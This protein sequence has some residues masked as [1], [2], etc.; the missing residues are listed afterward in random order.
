MI[1]IITA[2]ILSDRSSTSAETKTYTTDMSLKQ[3]APDLNVTGKSLARELGLSQPAKG[4]GKKP[5]KELGVT[6]EKLDEV[7]EHLLS[8]KGKVLKYYLFAALF[9]GGLIFMLKLGRPEKASG[10]PEKEWYPRMPYYT[11]LILSVAFAGFYL[12]KSPNPM[13]GIVKVF[14]S[15]AGLYPDPWVKLAAFIFF[16]LLAIIGNKIICGWACPFGALQE[17]IYSIPFLIN[18]ENRIKNPLFSNKHNSHRS[19]SADDYNSLRPV[20]S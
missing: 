1:I 13:E 8:H 15:M 20:W 5:L 9:T 4:S 10:S 3:L 17:L 6:K 12:G 2:G 16:I 14:K 19:F 18:N 7:V 11:I